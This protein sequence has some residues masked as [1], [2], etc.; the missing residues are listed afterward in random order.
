MHRYL[1]K[2]TEP[3]AGALH[4]GISGHAALEFANDQYLSTNKWPSA[5]VVQ[6]RF[7]REWSLQE[8][9]FKEKGW[10]ID[11]RTEKA[12]VIQQQMSSLLETYLLAPFKPQSAE[13][14][15]DID[16][17]GMYN[18]QSIK[19]YVGKIDLIDVNGNVIDYKFVTR[20]KGVT[21]MKYDL[22]PF[23]YAMAL[24][25]EID[26]SFVQFIRSKTNVADPM[27]NLRIEQ[28]W[29][30]RTLG[31]VEWYMEK[32]MPGLV[33]RA[34]TAVTMIYERYGNGWEWTEDLKLTTR[35]DEMFPPQPN[36]ACDS[37]CA[38]RKEGLCEFRI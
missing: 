28:G 11:W 20:K 14:K 13:Y 36:W 35:L 6:D 10:D 34:D 12:D 31:D 4:A 29:T 22:Q 24:D 16:L 5:T 7:K 32:F 9:K 8:A 23:S 17:R 19:N 21:D 3:P 15:F 27:N 2:V 25:R 38:Y 26:F 33:K 37:F 30:K 18:T 1:Y